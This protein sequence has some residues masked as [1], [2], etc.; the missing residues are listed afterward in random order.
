MS[1]IH[2]KQ[3]ATCQLS[4]L[5]K[6]REVVEH[7]LRQRRDLV[8]EEVAAQA[9]TQGEIGE[10]AASCMRTVHRDAFLSWH[11]CGNVLWHLDVLIYH[12][13]HNHWLYRSCRLDMF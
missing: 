7:A 2:N 12:T 11:V 3:A 10:A 6:Q 5:F 4:H 13:K 8:A 9:H 1:P